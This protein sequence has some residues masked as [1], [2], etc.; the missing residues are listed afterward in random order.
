MNAP[1][2]KADTSKAIK[3]VG[4]GVPAVGPPHA[5]LD[6]RLLTEPV[7]FE[8]ERLPGFV[9][10]ALLAVASLVILFVA[11][12]SVVHLDEV[13]TAA[14]QV[15]PS[16]AVKVIQHL[17][18]GVVSEILVSE[19]DTV[20]PSQI[21][22]RMD[23]IA[24]LS[25]LDQMKARLVGLLLRDERLKALAEKRKPNFGGISEGYP[26]LLA[27]QKNIWMSQI[28]EQ[29]SAIA[30]IDSQI[31]QK[32]KELKQLH[33]TLDTAIEQMKLAGEQVAIRKEGM[34]GGVVS[35]QTYLETQR[36]LVTAQG[37]VLRIREQIRVA[38]DSLT[39]VRRRHNNLGL[40]Q[41]QNALGEEGTVS[42]EIEQ[43]KKALSKLEDR[44]YRLDIRAPVVGHI[45]DL[46]IRSTG[47]V[48][49]AGGIVMRVVPMNDVLEAEVRINPT[50]I[51]Y[52]HASQPVKIKVA[53]YEYV[54]FGTLPGK[55]QKIS[56]STIADEHGA[57]YYRGVVSFDRSYLMGGEVKYPIIPG[58]AVEADIVTGTKTLIQYLLKPIFTSMKSSFHER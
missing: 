9:R 47:E 36:A 5:S 20:Q 4:G 24:A 23:P 51:G 38:T 22:M 7:L 50:D 31:D 29:S 21:V 37:E 41:I 19:G 54:R 3:V 57:P 28:A 8:E 2:L 35:R 15:V 44:V 34:E 42:A 25:E 18:G 6:A 39:E 48:V 30:V 45:Q 11:W 26:E 40:G 43:V 12:A 33:D 56:P 53:S 46:K 16:S 49:P 10:S 14:G 27:D 52:V 32:Q 17:E 13:A 58:M 1:M 55:L